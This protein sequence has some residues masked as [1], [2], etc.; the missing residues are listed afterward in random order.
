MV[1]GC[2]RAVIEEF[3]PNKMIQVGH[4]SAYGNQMV[5]GAIEKKLGPIFS[6]YKAI[7]K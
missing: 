2:T 6:R 4:Y 1:D 7:S 3:D 5:A